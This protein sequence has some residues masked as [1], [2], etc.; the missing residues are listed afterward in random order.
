[1]EPRA[2]GLFDALRINNVFFKIKQVRKD[3][4]KA[5]RSSLAP[6]TVSS[7]NRI[8]TQDVKDKA[9]KIALNYTDDIS[10]K[11]AV[12]RNATN[13]SQKTATSEAIASAYFKDVVGDNKVFTAKYSTGSDNGIDLLVDFGDGTIGIVE[14]K[15][16]SAGG[17]QLGTTSTMGDQMSNLWI[18]Q[19]A[20]KIKD[21]VPNES[22]KGDKILDAIDNNKIVKYVIAISK[23]APGPDNFD[24][25]H[26]YLLEII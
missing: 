19:V 9:A 10:A 16:F 22:W 3:Y 18:E 12:F 24:V 6:A 21:K 5:L 15:Q 26:L 1:L 20:N 4:F 11:A 25:E 8:L 2:S 13:N 17:I 14:V 23:E 7:A